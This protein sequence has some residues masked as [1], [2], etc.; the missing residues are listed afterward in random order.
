MKQRRTVSY[1][2]LAQAVGVA[3]LGLAAHVAQSQQPIEE[4]TVTG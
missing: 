3:C 4:V 2:G 1:N